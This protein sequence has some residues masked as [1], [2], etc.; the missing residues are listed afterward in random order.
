[1]LLSGE[2]RAGEMVRA[3]VTGALAYDLIAEPVA[4]PV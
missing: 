2:H 4:V 1:M 3:K